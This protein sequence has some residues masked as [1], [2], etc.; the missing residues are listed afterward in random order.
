[1]P[2]GRASRIA[3]VKAILTRRRRRKA[4]SNA[5]YD[6][7]TRK[8]AERLVRLLRKVGREGGSKIGKPTKY[9]ARIAKFLFADVPVAT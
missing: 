6:N 2:P 4:A 5:H 1:M 7:F 9:D 8:D 3:A